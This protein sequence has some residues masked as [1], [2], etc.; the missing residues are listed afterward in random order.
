MQTKQLQ[1]QINEMRYQI[2]A[3]QK[4]SKP[5]KVCGEVHWSE[6]GHVYRQFLKKSNYSAWEMLTKGRQE[7]LIAMTIC[8]INKRRSD[9]KI[10]KITGFD[11]GVVARKFI[12]KDTKI[13]KFEGEILTYEQHQKR[14]PQLTGHLPLYSFSADEYMIDTVDVRFASASRWCN[15]SGKNEKNNCIV[16]GCTENADDYFLTTTT[17]IL[18]GQQLLWSYPKKFG[19]HPCINSENKQIENNFQTANKKSLQDLTN[20]EIEQYNLRYQNK[21]VKGVM[22]NI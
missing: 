13:D 16:K 21:D 8:A 2:V 20:E 5:H 3:L 10:K 15:T 11:H 22:Y 7:S 12:A 9:I 17:N 6:T 14:Y 19:G 4:G 1:A 18:P